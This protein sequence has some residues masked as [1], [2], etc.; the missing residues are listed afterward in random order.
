M[1]KYFHLIVIL[2][3][4]SFYSLKA[5]ELPLKAILEAKI[6]ITSIQPQDPKTAKVYPGSTVTLQVEVKNSGNRPNAPGKIQIRFVLI[7][8]L[9]DLLESR[10][11]ATESLPLPIIYPGQVAVIKFTKE[12]Q[13]PSLH[14]FIKQNWNMRHYQ[15]VVKIDGEKEEKAIG[16]LP[17]FFSAYYYE[18]LNRATP[19]EVTFTE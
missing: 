13:W 18:G 7:E 5:H 14:D 6:H 4:G 19:R 12:H 2:L 16:F 10:T 1:H 9:E 11:F 3:M 8:P 17:I 15:A